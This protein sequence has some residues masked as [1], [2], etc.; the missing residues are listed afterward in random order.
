MRRF[1]WIK[2]RFNAVKN[3]H[4]INCEFIISNVAKYYNINFI[5]FNIIIVISAGIVEK[6]VISFS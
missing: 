3:F 4:D 5:S 2:V 1:S 6:K